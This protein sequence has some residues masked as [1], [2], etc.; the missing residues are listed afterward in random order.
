MCFNFNGYAFIVAG[1]V[2]TVATAALAYV[3]FVAKYN[4]DYHVGNYMFPS[5]A[6][7]ISVAVVAASC[8]SDD[9]YFKKEEFDQVYDRFVDISNTS[10]DKMLS[11]TYRQRKRLFSDFVKTVTLAPGEAV[12]FRH[13]KVISQRE[14]ESDF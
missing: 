2:L 13:A 6:I 7:M 3:I 5:F 9:Q 11:V 8:A 14:V 10:K 4:F 1:T 12:S